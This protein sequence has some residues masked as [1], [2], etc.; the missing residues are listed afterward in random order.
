MIAFIPVCLDRELTEQDPFHFRAEDE[1]EN[2]LAAPTSKSQN[3]PNHT[4]NF[5]PDDTL[6]VES[7]KLQFLINLLKNLRQEG[8][9]TLVFSQSRKMLDII[10]KVL[11]NQ[12]SFSPL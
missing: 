4:I 1:D 12:V 7:C 11:K 5:I 6:M 9:R 8:H 10:E 3:A 2:D